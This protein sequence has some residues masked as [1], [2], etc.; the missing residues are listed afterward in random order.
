MYIYIN[1]YIYV[2]VFVY[3]YI[4]IYIRRGC[5]PKRI[6]TLCIY[7]KFN[8]IYFQFEALYIEAI[9][10]Y[11]YIYIYIFQRINSSDEDSKY[12]VESS[13]QI[14]T[15]SGEHCIILLKL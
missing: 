3:V 15:I 12:R 5:A 10:I 9:Y 8:K 13:K 14:I 11:I 2:Y 1:M 4:Y 7:L 6:F